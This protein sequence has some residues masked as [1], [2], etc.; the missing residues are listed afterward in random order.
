MPSHQ[1]PSP[2]TRQ[3]GEATG[4]PYL[5]EQKTYR[6]RL[7]YSSSSV[8]C[9]QVKRLKFL[10]TRRQWMLSGVRFKM[11][12]SRQTRTTAST[13]TRAK[14]QSRTSTSGNST[15]WWRTCLLRIS[16]GRS[17]LFRRPHPECQISRFV[18][19]RE[20]MFQV[21]HLVVER[22]RHLSPSH[23]GKRVHRQ[24]LIL[25]RWRSRVEYAAST[26]ATCPLSKYTRKKERRHHGK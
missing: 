25:R 18:S 20:R 19:R 4:T 3:M 16:R 17:K 26:S 15:A 1:D 10:R 11:H 23:L 14:D 6:R 9:S 2:E 13:R 8:I 7:L 5:T 22:G 21:R 24:T 12:G